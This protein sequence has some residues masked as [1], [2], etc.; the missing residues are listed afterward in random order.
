MPARKNLVANKFAHWTVM[1]YA[2]RR[3]YGI[4]QAS[5]VGLWL[6]KCDCAAGTTGILRQSMLISGKTT[7]CGCQRKPSI[8]YINGKETPTHVSYRN[9]LQRCSNPRDIGFS[10]Y[11]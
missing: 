1:K 8:A 7:H 9:M 6:C 3:R 10:R 11:G 5:S 4:S 2:G